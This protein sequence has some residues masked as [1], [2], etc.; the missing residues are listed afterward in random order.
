MKEIKISN[1][2]IKIEIKS[3]FKIDFQDLRCP[4]HLKYDS[5]EKPCVPPSTLA[6]RVGYG[7]HLSHPLHQSCFWSSSWGGEA[8][9][10]RETGGCAVMRA[11]SP[12]T[13]GA[14]RPLRSVELQELR[15]SRGAG[16]SE[17][18]G[19]GS[20]P[21]RTRSS[22]VHTQRGDRAGV[23]PA[24]R[25][26]RGQPR[27]EPGRDLGRGLRKRA[28]G[29]GLQPPRPPGKACGCEA[30]PTC[31]PT[32]RREK[33]AVPGCSTREPQRWHSTA[34]RFRPS[35]DT[36]S[37][38]G[39][40]GSIAAAATASSATTAQ[41][42]SRW[43]LSELRWRGFQRRGRERTATPPLRSRPLPP[44]P[45]FYCAS[46]SFIAYPGRLGVAGFVTGLL[47]SW[48][49]T[50]PLFILTWSLAFPYY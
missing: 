18:G 41:A 4:S 37:F 16:P 39:S 20:A 26:R 40:A 27:A 49:V 21:H 22:S 46:A 35:A 28:R 44:A 43:D 47:T 25:L 1:L 33:R 11:A 6:K 12:G 17:A 50:N 3:S 7:N 31:L 48:D 30:P 2:K 29:P 8:P 45:G 24:A 23:P 36:K 10:R 14:I 38:S 42:L 19:L 32:C 13:P 34:F 15:E 9:D 5:F